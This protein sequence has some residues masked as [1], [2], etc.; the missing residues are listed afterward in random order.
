MGTQCGKGWRADAS[1]DKIGNLGVGGLDKRT[2]ESRMG[3]ALVL[4]K[5]LARFPTR[6]ATA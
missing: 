3:V 5:G 1:D 4:P 6:W 2:G